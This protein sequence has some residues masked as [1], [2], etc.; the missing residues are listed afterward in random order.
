MESIFG[1]TM[2]PSLAEWCDIIEGKLEEPGDDPIWNVA[3]PEV[4]DRPFDAIFL[5]GGGAGRFGAAF[6]RARGGRPLII[7]KWPF[8]GGSCP[9]EACVPHH[10]LSECAKELDRAKWFSGQLWFP[11]FDPKK[12]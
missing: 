2:Y 12:V 1:K 8:L 11:E 7:E 10:I 5:G 9:H 6:M 3:P 4:D